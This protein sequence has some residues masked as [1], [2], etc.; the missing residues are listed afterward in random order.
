MSRTLAI[1]VIVLT[2]V[3]VAALIYKTVIIE[4]FEVLSE[5]ES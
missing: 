3:T 2:I 5:E 1:F 4:D